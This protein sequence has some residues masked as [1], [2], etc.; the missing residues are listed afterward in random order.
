MLTLDQVEFS[1]GDTPILNRVSLDVSSGT[2]FGIVGANGSGKTTLMRLIAGIIKPDNGNISLFGESPSSKLW[3]RIGYMPQM[4]ALYED[5][6]VQQNL[7][8][9]ARMFGISKTR[10]RAE[11]VETTINMVS[12]WDKRHR[13]VSKLSGGERQR[14]SLG[15]AL[16]HTPTLLLL[17]EPTVG[18]DPRLRLDLWKHFYD[19]ADKGTTLIISSHV[20]DD[21]QKCKEIGFLQFGRMIAIGTPSQLIEATGK[22]DSSLEDAFLYFIDQE[23][24]R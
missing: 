2:I 3:N 23:N 15:I 8:F 14:V 19:L 16:V 7:N 13:P 6:T 17:D 24:S 9:F 10:Y 11:I 5:L 12:L 1:Y 20:M 22:Q 18:L 4:Q 21:A